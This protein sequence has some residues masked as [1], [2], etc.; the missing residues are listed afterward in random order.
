MTNQ[1]KI[2]SGPSILG[3]AIL[4]AIRQAVREEIKA[5]MSEPTTKGMPVGIGHDLSPI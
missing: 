5:A 1:A 4:G 3:D 2:T